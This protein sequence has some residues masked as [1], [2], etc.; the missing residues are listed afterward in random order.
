V[1][2]RGVAACLAV[3]AISACGTL[4][5]PPAPPATATPSPLCGPAGDWTSD[6][7]ARAAL[8]QAAVPSPF[9]PNGDEPANPDQLQ[10]FTP[11]PSGDVVA[12]FVAGFRRQWLAGE[13]GAGHVEMWAFSSEQ[14]ASDW[15]T[16]LGEDTAAH[17]PTG[18]P[19]DA[20][21]GGAEYTTQGP[22]GTGYGI[23]AE[24]SR[25]VFEVALGG[26]GI[27]RSNVEDLARTQ[28]DRLCRS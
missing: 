18:T 7:L 27:T 21:P 23:L 28:Y 22:G 10:T 15:Q 17:G 2:R 3:V 24:R 25:V 4:H 5:L 20:V 9:A 16:Q 13:A 11:R 14:A 1:I 6:A 19:S 12:G 26:P 8:P